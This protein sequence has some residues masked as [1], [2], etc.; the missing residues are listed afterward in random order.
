MILV[1]G[2]IRF[3][4]IFAGVP[5]GG[6][7]NEIG[8]VDDGYI[9]MPLSSYFPPKSVFGKNSVAAKMRILTPTAQI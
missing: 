6:V 1:S 4:E 7:S 5:V 3:M 9:R 8:V 2:N